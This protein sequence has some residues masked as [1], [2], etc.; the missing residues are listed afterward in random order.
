MDI[1]AGKALGCRTVLVTTGPQSPSPH[2]QSPIDVPDYV[3]LDLLDAS[4]WIIATANKE[5]GAIHEYC[6]PT[7][8]PNSS[9]S[10]SLAVPGSDAEIEE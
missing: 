9:D 1:D 8:Y 5:P 6:I 7:K 3:A 4:R 2:P 10:G